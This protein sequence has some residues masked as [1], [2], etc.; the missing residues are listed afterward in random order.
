MGDRDML[1]ENI[2]AK[3]ADACSKARIVFW[4]DASGEFA[5]DVRELD[6]PGVTVVDVRGCA[7]ATKRRVLRDERDG[8]FLL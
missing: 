3:L 8:N 5:Q 2:Q 4:E 7:L 1:D 6:L